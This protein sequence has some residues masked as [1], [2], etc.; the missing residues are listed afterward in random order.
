MH[1]SPSDAK[2]KLLMEKYHGSES[3]AYRADCA[4][5]DAHEPYQYL[6]GYADFLDCRIDLSARPMIPRDET[7]FWLRR[8]ID[9]WEDAGPITTLDLYAGS[10]N[11]GITLLRHL[12]ESRV[13]F[14]EYDASL[15]PG[16]ERSLAL[17]GI[18]RD[19]ATLLSGDSLSPIHGRFDVIVANPPYLD[20]A[21]DADMDPEMRYEPRLAFYGSDDGYKHHRE[22][23]AQGRDHLGKDGVLYVQCDMTQADTLKSLVATT[24]WRW[25]VWDDA[26][27]NPGVLVLRP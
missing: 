14:S 18:S 17:N 3:A 2:K 16:I 23:I 20:P 24:S 12:P 8:V 21:L 9:E 6:L 19:R 5:I 25:D 1:L 26:Y 10:G 11:M 7:A 13:T 27:G 22:L 4:R 15:L